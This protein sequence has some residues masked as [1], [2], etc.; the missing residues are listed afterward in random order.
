LAVFVNSGEIVNL[1]KHVIS[2]KDICNGQVL[3]FLEI[4]VYNTYD[5][6]NFDI[7]E[8]LLDDVDETMNKFNED[9]NI[10]VFASVEDQGCFHVGGTNNNLKFKIFSNTAHN[11]DKQFKFHT[12]YDVSIS[13]ILKKLEISGFCP[14]VTSKTML[15]IASDDMKILLPYDQSTGNAWDF[16]DR[17]TLYIRNVLIKDYQRAVQMPFVT[18]FNQVNI[19]ANIMTKQILPDVS[20]NRLDP[21]RSYVVSYALNRALHLAAAEQLGYTKEESNLIRSFVKRFYS[22]DNILVRK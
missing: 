5:E 21:Q 3:K 2:L 7:V 4:P 12:V 8:D 10:I 18:C 14:K 22:K 17:S 1:D 20:R 6:D 15:V 11:T 9:D 19:Y 13:E 16:T